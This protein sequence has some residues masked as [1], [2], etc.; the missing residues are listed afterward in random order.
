ML[1]SLFGKPWQSPPPTGVAVVDEFPRELSIQNITALL[2]AV[3]FSSPPAWLR[4]R[5]TFSNG[6]RF[7]AEMALALAFAARDKTT[8]LLDE[9]TSVVDRNAAKIGCVA[10]AKKIHQANLRFVAASCHED[11]LE[12]LQP[13]WV[14]RPDLGSFTWRSLQPRPPLRLEFRRVSKGLW[15]RFHAHHYLSGALHPAAVCFGLFL[16]DPGPVAFSA[17]LPFV[18]KGPKA[19][20]EHRTVCL[21][22]FQGIGLGSKISELCA[23]LWRGLGYR[24]LSTTS[25]PAMVRSRNQ[26]PHW[27][28]LRPPSLVSKR[29]GKRGKGH[30]A[31]GRFT[32]GFEYVGPPMDPVLGLKILGI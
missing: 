8:L 28:M 30:H 2:S 10:F 17:W 3:G 16:S 9:F 13:D 22:D 25:H 5:T 24:S 31:T 20:R 12:W 19:R 29:S 15:R 26:H 6:Q 32:A 11:I 4:P 14:A 23:S 27:R 7:R 21:P 18:G 1:Q